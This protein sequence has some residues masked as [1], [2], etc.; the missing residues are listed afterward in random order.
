[1]LLLLATCN[2]GGISA[3]LLQNAG[4]F[5]HDRVGSR[6]GLK[7]N[8]VIRPR[9]RCAVTINGVSPALTTVSPS[10]NEPT[11]TCNAANSKAGSSAASVVVVVVV[12]S[13]SA[14]VGI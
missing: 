3:S 2:A 6:P 14:G 9:P 1:M 4:K 13:T 10:R 5:F 7:S 8:A 11:A 12:A